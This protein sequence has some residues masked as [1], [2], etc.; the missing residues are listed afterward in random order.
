MLLASWI[1]TSAA[2]VATAAPPRIVVIGPHGDDAIRTRLGAELSALGFEVVAA[3]QD[4][5]TPPARAQLEAVAREAGAVAAVRLVP[6]PRGVEVWIVDRV[7]GKTVLRDLSPPSSGLPTLTASSRSASSNSFAHR[8]SRSTPSTPR[9]AEIEPPPAVREAAH[10][11][12]NV[13]LRAPALVARAGATLLVSPGGTPPGA[14]GLLAA[15]WMPRAQLGLEAFA[16]T[17]LFTSHLDAP[18]GSASITSGLAGAGL[19]FVLGSPRA[20]WLPTAGLG[21]AALWLDARGTPKAHFVGH[22]L[23]VITPAPTASLGLGVA[24]APHLRLRAD[25]V[26]AVALRRPVVLFANREVA[27]WGRPLFAPSFGFELSWP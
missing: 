25:L 3:E 21:L 4:P 18:E 2:T 23:Q 24:I 15:G 6:S 5:S 12:P 8:S 9:A 11:P 1:V 17:T 19:R 13:E 10:L 7:T 26:T 14:G 20:T 16:A 27:S 22:A